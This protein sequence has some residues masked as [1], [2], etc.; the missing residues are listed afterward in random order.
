MISETTDA[1]REGFEKFDKRLVEIRQS[2][3]KMHDDINVGFEDMRY[4]N[5]TQ[6][7]DGVGRGYSREF[8]P[9]ALN[10]LRDDETACEHWLDMVAER[11]AGV[12]ADYPRWKRA[13]WRDDALEAGLFFTPP[14]PVGP[15][16][17][18][19]APVQKEPPRRMSML[20]VLLFTFVWWIAAFIGLTVFITIPV[21]M[22]DEAVNGPYVSTEPRELDPMQ[23]VTYIGMALLPVIFGL[24]WLRRRRVEARAREIEQYN[25][26]Q[27]LAYFKAARTP[28]RGSTRRTSGSGGTSRRPTGPPATRRSATSPSRSG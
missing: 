8:R 22:Y 24:M 15:A 9:R 11:V 25:Q 1:V 16:A 13:E 26:E 14:E 23:T 3:E 7:R 27:R 2:I 20:R 5:Y 21:R 18:L 4:I 19:P 10:Y 28:R 12:T 17:P 6:W